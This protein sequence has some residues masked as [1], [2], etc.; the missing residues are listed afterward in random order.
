[1]PRQLA[2]LS[3]A[4]V[5][6]LTACTHEETPPPAPAP[7]DITAARA[8]ADALGAQ[9]KARLLS[10]IETGG[11]VA[12]IDVCKLEAPE[13]AAGLSGETGLRVG[14]TALR[15]RNP[16][17]APDDYER[18]AM[19]TFLAEIDAGADPAALELAEIVTGAQGR[20]LRYMKPIMTGGPCVLC[21]GTDISNEVKAAILE[22]YPDDQATGFAPGDFR[23]A[24]TI[25]KDLEK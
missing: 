25:T 4:A 14:R 2:V 23:G 13:I 21:H 8:A 9:L 22:R 12:A 16:A 11:P 20:Q 10:A 17:N 24:F 6:V 7:E 3:L 5:F 15:W 18:T 1:M 19:E